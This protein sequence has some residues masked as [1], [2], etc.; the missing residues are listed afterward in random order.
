MS[1]PI[2]VL[3]VLIAVLS[4]NTVTADKYDDHKTGKGNDNFHCNRQCR[5]YYGFFE[6]SIQGE[7]QTTGGILDH[8]VH[9]ACSNLGTAIGTAPYYTTDHPVNGPPTVPNYGFG[10]FDRLC[11]AQGDNV[12]WGN[13]SHPTGKCHADLFPYAK[14]FDGDYWADNCW[15]N[16][17]IAG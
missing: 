15:A 10:V 8:K 1:K 16:G 4:A 12:S 2:A 14:P 11:C 6:R 5:W 17:W 13:C 9:C 3:P 7:R